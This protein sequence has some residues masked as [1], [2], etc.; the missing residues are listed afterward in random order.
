[1]KLFRRAACFL[2]ALTLLLS[3]AACTKEKADDSTEEEPSFTYQD[4][5]EDLPQESLSDSLEDLQ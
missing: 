1:M 2:T 5:Q 3:L 4:S